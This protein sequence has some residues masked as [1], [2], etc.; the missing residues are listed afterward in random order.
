MGKLVRWLDDEILRNRIPTLRRDLLGVARLLWWVEAKVFNFEGKYILWTMKMEQY[1]AHT[2]YALWEV[3]LNGNSVVQMTKVEADEHLA[4]FHRI[5]DAKTLWAA[6]K[7]RFG[8]NVESKK[9]QKNVLKQQSENFSVSNSEGLDKGYD[10]FQRLLSLL[11]IHRACVSTEDANQKFLRSLPSAWSNISLIMRNKPCIDNLDINDLYKNL[12]VYEADIKGSSGSSSN[13]QNVA[14]ISAE[15]TGSTNELNAAYSVSTATGHSS[16][17]QGSSSYADKLMFSFFATQSN[18]SHLDNENLEQIDQDDLE[19]MNLKWQVAMLFMRVKRIYKKTGR[20]LEFNRKEPIGFDKTKVK[21]YNCHRRGHFARD[22]RSTRNSGNRSRDVGNAGYGGRD[23]EEKA[24]DFTLMAFTLNPSSSSSSNSKLDE[25]LREKEDL[26]AKLENFETSSKNLTKLLDSQISAKVK[27]GLGYDSQFHE[28][29]VLDIREEEVTE[30]MFYNHSSDEENSLANDRFKKDIMAKKSVLP[31]NVGKGTSHREHR[32]V[33][34]NVQRINH[35]NKFASTAVFTRSFYNATTHSKRNSTERVNIAE[36]EAVSAVKGNRVT[37]VKT[38]AGNK[39][40]LT[41]YQEI[42]DGGFVAFGSSRDKISGK[43]KIRTEKIDF[44]DV[45]FVNELK[46]NLFSVSQMCDKKNSVLFTETIC[47]VLSP[48]FKL[49]NESQVLLRVPKESN[50]YSFDLHNV[51][52]SRDLTCLFV[53]ASIH[54]SNLW[55]IRLSHVNF[56]T[57]NKLVK[58]NLVR[59]LPLKIFKNDHTYVACQK[60]KKHKATLT[61]DFSR[62]RWVFFLASKDETSKVLK[63][64]ITAI[65]NQINKKVKVIRCDNRTEFKNKDLDELCGMKRSRGNIEIP[66]LHKAV[67]TACYVL[68]RAL[69]TKTHNKTPYELLNGRTPRLDFMRPFGCS[70]TIL[71]T[72]DPVGKFEGKAD[73]GF[74]V[75]YSEPSKAFRLMSQEKEAGDAADALRQ[76]FE[77]GCIDQRGVTNSG[78]TNSF[79]TVSH[80][81]NHASTS[82]TFSAAGPS[83]PHPDAFIPANT[84]LHVDQD[85]SQIHYLEDTAKLQSTGIFNVAYDDDLD[86]FD[87]SVQS[88]GAEADFNNME[89]STIVSHIPTHRVHLHHPKDRILGDPKIFL[90]FASYMGFVVYQMDVKSAFLYGTMEEEVYVSQHPV[91]IDPQFLNKVNKVEKALY[92]LHQAPRAWYLKGQAKLDLWYPRD[93][94]FDLEVYSDS[95]Y[96]GANLDRKSITGVLGVLFCVGVSGDRSWED[97]GRV[98]KAGEIMGE[99]LQVWREFLVN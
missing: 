98:E 9:M 86:I 92:G 60:G 5:K 16:Q 58:G 32:P 59:G 12:K 91:F 45:Y 76:K 17:A 37:A 25:A 24:T 78:S 80:L 71:N 68:N 21:C 65:E 13:L 51:V 35:Q 73:E 41:D 64:F 27:T 94:P 29:K 23:N 40:Y 79:N 56:K 84:L 97:V 28:K 22:C 2:N 47:L 42:N 39:A 10:R 90:A 20:K 55:H 38:S 4:R 33:W 30:T 46:F 52:P 85:D 57:M 95:D 61:D 99:G 54:E 19:E 1:L 8:G 48:N 50:M 31:T 74:L 15:S 96:A 67:N 93:S 77:Q 44:D 72:L 26:K 82:R 63:P 69:V 87:S 6:I 14:F 7:T 36:L 53:K 62:F 83:S 11:E 43:G 34:N 81:I 18:T 88:V 75:G 70:V 66:E 49:L 3:I 89:S